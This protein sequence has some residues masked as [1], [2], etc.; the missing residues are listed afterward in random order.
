MS[1][2]TSPV[3]FVSACGRL[4]RFVSD[5]G[6]VRG[7]SVTATLVEGSPPFE[8][9]PKAYQINLRTG[10]AQTTLRVD[11]ETFTDT[12]EFFSTLVVPQLEAA[13]GSLRGE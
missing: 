11:H 9:G 4:H 1:K 7:I 13:I 5:L 10:S 8:G 6:S 3:D 2:L 12:E